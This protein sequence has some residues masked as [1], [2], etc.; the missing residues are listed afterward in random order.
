MPGGIVP[1]PSVPPGDQC[2]LGVEVPENSNSG[3]TGLFLACASLL[4]KPGDSLRLRTAADKS[5]LDVP[6]VE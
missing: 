4:A 1:C 6:G 5:V 3:V 2:R